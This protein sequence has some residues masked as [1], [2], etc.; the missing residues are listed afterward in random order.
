[1]FLYFFG[2]LFVA[3]VFTIASYLLTAFLPL[4]TY[5]SAVLV[6]SAV[7]HLYLL[8]LTSLSN[9]IT[10]NRIIYISLSHC[11]ELRPHVIVTYNG[12]YFDWPYVDKRCAKYGI[13]LYSDLGIKLNA[14]ECH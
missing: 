11:Q 3:L 2:L 8:F 1:M 13:S 6:T 10:S 12:D 4:I 7:S 5:D 14:G 9:R